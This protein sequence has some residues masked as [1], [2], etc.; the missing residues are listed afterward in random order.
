MPETGNSFLELTPYEKVVL[1]TNLLGD[2]NVISSTFFEFDRSKSDLEFNDD[3]VRTGL[4]IL[5]KRHPYLRASIHVNKTDENFIAKAHFKIASSARIE[6]E[7]LELSDSN[8]IIKCMEDFNSKLFTINNDGILWRTQL[9]SYYENGTKKYLINLVVHLTICDGINISTL[10]LELINILNSLLKNHEC[11]EMKVN[12]KPS[13]SLNELAKLKGLFTQTQEDMVNK[14]SQKS[15]AVEFI[16][17]EKF[18]SLNQ[19]G[20]KIN[21]IRLDKNLTRSLINK[22]KLNDVRITGCL[23]TAI[24]YALKD[25][26]SLNGLQPPN[27]FCCDMPANMRIRHRPDDLKFHDMRLQVCLAH[28][29]TSKSQFGKYSN[30]WSD[31][32]YVNSLIEE[33]TSVETGTIYSLSHNIDYLEKFD[34]EFNKASDQKDACVRLNRKNKCDLLL[35]NIGTHLYKNKK[36]VSGPIQIN[37]TYFG[38]SLISDPNV[39][40]AIMFHVCFWSDEIMIQLSSNKS[41]IGSTYTEQLVECFMSNLRKSVA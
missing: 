2:F 38:D 27:E 41:S 9:I 4:N 24:F 35:S 18:K 29:E 16:L 15:G 30:F 14:L 31:V 19:T 5:C 28:F 34:A 33:C 23:N 10:S 12:L 17:D 3:L 11:E 13:L 20:L 8:E 39:L 6:F 22:C 26:Y 1:I 37:E 32:K 40:P 36:L 25:L 7:S 21:L